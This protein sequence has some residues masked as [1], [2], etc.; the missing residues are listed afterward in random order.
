MKRLE[1]TPRRATQTILL[2]PVLGAMAVPT[3][4]VAASGTAASSA[5][6]TA[7]RVLALYALTVL[8]INVMTGSLRPLLVKVF[9][10][11]ILFR[12]HNTAGLVGFSMAVAHMILVITYGL[13]PGFRKL[14]PITLYIFTVTTV[15]IL[16]RKYMKKRWR[17]VHRLNYA[18]FAVALV[19]AFQVGTDVAA[20][21]FLEVMLYIYAALA[22]AGFVYRI[23]LEIRNRL[24][25]RSSKGT[26]G[27]GLPG[28]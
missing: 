1:G 4:A 11:G 13:W 21:A 2:L 22:A 16:L 14:G 5:T 7:L 17:A 6:W 12:V 20:V 15:A 18:V 27:V 3:I 23:Q 25:K 28:D 26:A 10:P 24:R 8:F 9:N 19:H